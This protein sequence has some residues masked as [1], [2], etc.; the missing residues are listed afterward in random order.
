MVDTLIFI[1]S[2]AAIG[3]LIGLTAVG[4]GVL[5]VPLLILVGR[6]QPIEAVGTASLYAVL[7][8]IYA[9]L[10]HYSQ[11]TVNFRVGLRFL[12]PGLPGVLLSSVLVKWAKAT[13]PA[14][15]V[16]T[17]QSVISYIVTFAICFSL[18]VLFFDYSKVR[19]DLF[20]SPLGQSFKFLCVFLIG[21]IAGA[22][23]I[24]GGILIIPVLLLFYRETT[25]YVGTSIFCGLLMLGVVS[26][27]YAF[28][29]QGS[30]GG[31]VN[32]RAAVLMSL[33]SLAGAHYGSALSKR[34]HPRRLQYVVIA[35]VAFAAIVMIVDRAT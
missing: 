21:A 19:S 26:V 2:G 5:A 31:D 33:G 4:G 7:T 9:V 14:E 22:T 20:A 6:L 28:L 15:D 35:V 32:L 10:K 25:R 23:S 11:Q 18:A 13:L 24:G 29:G 12:I 1:A 17:L 16:M 3:F 27:V 8:K 30:G 34:L